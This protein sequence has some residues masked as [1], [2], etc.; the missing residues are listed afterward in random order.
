MKKAA[1]SLGFFS[2]LSI[3]SAIA[4]NV[5]VRPSFPAPADA[6]APFTWT[7]LYVGGEL[8]GGWRSSQATLDTGNR[9]RSLSML[10][11]WALAPFI[12]CSANT[13]YSAV[14]RS[15]S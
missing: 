14:S 10:A 3:S 9:F 7:G 13:S 5:A 6:V 11:Y 15:V 8:G 1:F 2:V 4:A 12:C